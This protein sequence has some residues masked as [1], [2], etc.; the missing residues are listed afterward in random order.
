MTFLILCFAG[1]FLAFALIDT[2]A[3]ARK[4]APSPAWR[5]R[6]MLSFALYVAVA[7][8]A[9]MMW[10]GLLSQH[11]LFDASA[12]PLWIQIILG[13]GALQFGIYVWHRTMHAIT[14][15]WRVFH[16][17]HHSAERVDIWG[18]FWFHPL[19]SA[20]F[21]F[22]GSLA[23][24]GGIGL[25]VTAAIT[26]SLMAAFCAMFQHANLRTP[27]WLGYFITRPESHV[28][29]HGRDVHAFNYGDVPWFDMLLGT[30][31]NPERAPEEAGFH[32]GASLR[33]F[34]ML[35]FQDVSKPKRSAK[36]S[37]PAE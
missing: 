18:A 26:I 32:D 37:V 19:D 17:M 16:Q 13:F 15:L 5:V 31:R 14:P 12:F 33:L 8:T 36:R 7:F 2:F 24:V 10:D 4:L 29:H 22:I 27:R 6:G 20:G 25:E 11:T 35:T 23:L 28:L 21:A 3:P 1:M 30:F 34:E 9:P